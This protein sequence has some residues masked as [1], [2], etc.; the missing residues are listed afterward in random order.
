MQCRVSL[1]LLAS[2][3]LYLVFVYKNDPESWQAIGVVLKE[4]V[5]S[6]EERRSGFVPPVFHEGPCTGTG[7]CAEGY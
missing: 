1:C 3:G 5:S 7:F 2:P 4:L 6:T